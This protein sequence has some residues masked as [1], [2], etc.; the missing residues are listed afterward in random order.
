MFRRSSRHRRRKKTENRAKNRR[1]EDNGK[2][3]R[4]A[5]YHV[6]RPLFYA[7]SRYAKKD[8]SHVFV[9]KKQQRNGTDHAGGQRKKQGADAACR[10]CESQRGKPGVRCDG[11][12][13]K[14]SQAACGISK[15]RRMGIFAGGIFLCVCCRK[16]QAAAVKIQKRRAPPMTGCV[17]NASV[18][19]DTMEKSGV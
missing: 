8:H 11:A 4:M 13:T 16:R 9:Q 5:W 6:V 14:K 3:G 18:A 2:D 19:G 7:R 17:R 1:M 12:Y 10:L 15:K